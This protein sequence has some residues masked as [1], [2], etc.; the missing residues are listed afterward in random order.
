M[1]SEGLLRRH[2]IVYQAA[3]YKLPHRVLHLLLPWAIK[4]YILQVEYTYF[5]TLPVRN[6]GS[7][8]NE[9]LNY[10]LKRL[11]RCKPCRMG[12]IRSYQR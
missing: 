3:K 8:M 12:F 4:I 7:L 9:Q 10:E 1:Y 6:S 2:K 11:K 5:Y